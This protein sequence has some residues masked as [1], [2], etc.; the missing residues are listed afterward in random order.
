M[1]PSKNSGFTSGDIERYHSGKLSPEERHAL[2]K[3][4][5]DDPF[6]ADALEGYAF[7]STPAADL[8]S[9]QSRLDEKLNQR[10]LIPLFQK[11]KWLSVAAIFLFIAGGVWLAYSIS[12]KEKSS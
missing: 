10:K 1:T 3:A 11:Y 6:L 5:L 9:I 7:T 8:A 4:A 12:Y 2:E